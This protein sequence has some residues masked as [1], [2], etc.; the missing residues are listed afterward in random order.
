[1]TV[2]KDDI[3]EGT[4]T[5]ITNFGAFV[6][7]DDKTTGLVHISEIADTFVKDIN[8]LYKI[9]DTVKVKI[10]KIDDK[11]KLVLSIKKVSAKPAY[12]PRDDFRHS[13]DDFRKSKR[14]MVTE[15]PGPASFEDKLARF[16]KDSEE[17]Q[18]D[19]KRSK[20]LTRKKKKSR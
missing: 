18:L 17:I 15:D 10:L 13:G 9:G 8:S 1:M 19:A 5:G 7:I 12:T 3:V 16:L 4:I 11:G 20:D 6:K 14:Q 2:K